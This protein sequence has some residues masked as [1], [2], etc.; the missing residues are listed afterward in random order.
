MTLKTGC[1]VLVVDDDPFIRHILQAMLEAEGC[2]VL[3]AENGAEGLDLLKREICTAPFTLMVLDVMMPKMTGL[4][5][6]VELRKDPELC[7]LPVLMLTAEG[8]PDDVARGYAAGASF[9]MT[10]PFDR[11][12]LLGGVQAA[13][14]GR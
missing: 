10:K 14:Q 7:N 9:Y 12:Q 11:E 13:L 3:L 1:R 2:T 4:E 8:K 6:L 5:M